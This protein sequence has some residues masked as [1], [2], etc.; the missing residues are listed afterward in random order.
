MKSSVFFLTI[1]MMVFYSTNLCAQALANP[2]LLWPSGAPDATGDS[3]EDKPALIP[4]IPEANVRNGAAVLVIPGG[5]FTIRAVDHEGVLVAQWLKSKGITAF[6]LRYRLRPLYERKDW[7]L[8]SQRG[9]QYIRAHASEYHI[10]TDRVGAV[11]FSAGANLIADLGFHP[12]TVDMTSQDPLDHQRSRPD[13]DILAYGAMAFPPDLDVETIATIPPTFMFGTVEDGGSIN[14]MTSLFTALVKNKVPVETHFFRNGVHGTGFAIGDPILGEWTHLLHN[15]MLAGGWLTEKART[16][17]NGVVRL[18]GQPL[19]RGMIVLTPVENKNDPPVIIYMTNTGTDEL[20]RFKVIKD[21]GPVEGRYKVELRQEATRW[22][23]NSRDP[24][25]I[26]M[27]AKER[28]KTLSDADRRAWGEYLRKRDLSPSIDYQ[29]VFSK[30]R[31]GDTG[32]YIIEV[33][34]RKDLRIEVFSK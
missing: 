12:A 32:D 6:L 10:S 22:T 7:L 17:I 24:F 3:D 26:R 30:Q 16:E 5:G 23:S 21:Q 20:G 28:D 9:M 1:V 13:F 31:P 33:D 2:I 27:M 11:G 18:D 34:G 8:D 14:G 4:F 29:K 19:L 25:M 15:W